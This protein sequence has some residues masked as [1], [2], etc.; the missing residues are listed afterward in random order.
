M[1]TTPHLTE[2]MPSSKQLH[3]PTY[4]LDF[5]NRTLFFNGIFQAANCFRIHHVAKIQAHVFPDPRS[6]RT[7]SISSEIRRHRFRRF[8]LQ[9]R[10]LAQNKVKYASHLVRKQILVM[11]RA[12]FISNPFR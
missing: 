11:L 1:F 10:R 8:P 4:F 3:L 9:K 12:C 5:R 7:H 2:S 6:G